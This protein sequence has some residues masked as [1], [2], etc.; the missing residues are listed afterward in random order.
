MPDPSDDMLMALADDQLHGADA[1]ALRQRI[2]DDPAL[3]ARFAVFAE[4]RAAL[5]AAF[6][7][8]ATPEW[9]ETSV[10]SA[11]IGDTRSGATLIRFPA[12][13]A[14]IPSLALA[15]SLLL[16]VGVGSFLVGR[17]VAPAP[18]LADPAAVAAAA[19]ETFGT[20]AET[21]IPG[22]GVA[23]VLGSYQTDQGLCRLIDLDLAGDRTERAVVC[24]TPDQSW[25]VTA[26]IAAGQTEV[27]IPASDTA[28]A[29]IDQVL[30][31]M[32]AGPALDQAAEANALANE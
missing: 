9:L 12:R 16:A 14:M 1:D 6:T 22:D 29:V 25:V 10:R 23:R 11:P 7:P 8:G 27:Y 19:L 17:S 4:S 28:A 32:G 15:A 13:R 20:G 24:R 2:S 5:Q 21:A 26:A 3:A 31:D 30:D 18:V